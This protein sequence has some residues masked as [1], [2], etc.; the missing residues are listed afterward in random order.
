[1][2]L[3]HSD[4]RVA[5]AH[6]DASEGRPQRGR[7]IAHGG[8]GG[9]SPGGP[10][11]RKIVLDVSQRKTMRSCVF[12]STAHHLTVCQCIHSLAKRQH[13]DKTWQS[14]LRKSPCGT[15]AICLNEEKAGY[16]KH[17]IT[18]CNSASKEISEILS[19]FNTIKLYNKTFCPNLISF[20]VKVVGLRHKYQ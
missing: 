16:R 6:S 11:H 7:L 10:G 18:K 20:S 3:S 2:T 12:D 5:R 19:Q 14:Q 13:H 17:K 1:M 9:R 8:W 4:I 15:K